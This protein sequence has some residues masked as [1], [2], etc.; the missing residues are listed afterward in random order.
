MRV[1]M[2]KDINRHVDYNHNVIDRNT[3]DNQENVNANQKHSS[4]NN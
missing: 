4:D 3:Y 1:M 2:G